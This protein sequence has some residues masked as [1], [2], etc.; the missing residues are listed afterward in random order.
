MR[1]E[2][3][4]CVQSVCL[5]LKEMPYILAQTTVFVPIVYF[6]IGFRRNENHRFYNNNILFLPRK[7]KIHG[8]LTNNVIH[9]Y[10][11]LWY[12]LHALYSSWLRSQLQDSRIG[13][14]KKNP[15]GCVT[16]CF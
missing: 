3:V 13:N 7:L 11:G 10:C 2:H 9:D 1:D 16:G 5:F 12:Q 15:I 6:M 8:C 4:N 14:N